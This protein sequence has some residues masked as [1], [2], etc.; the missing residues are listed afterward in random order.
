MPGTAAPGRPQPAAR[1][2]DDAAAR[3]GERRHA[4]PRR[5]RFLRVQQHADR[6]VGRSGAHHLHRRH[7]GRRAARP[8]RLPPGPLAAG[9]HRPGRARLRSRR[10]ARRA[11]RTRERQGASGT[12]ADVP[13]GHRRRP[14]RARRRDQARARRAAPVPAVG[15]GQQRAHERT[16]RPRTRQPLLRI[17]APPPARLRLHRGGHQADPQP[18][19]GHRQGAARLDGQRYAD[20][21][22]LRPQPHAVRLLHAE[23]RAGHQ[24]AARLGARTDRHLSWNRRSAPSRTCWRTPNC[25]PRRS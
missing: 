1:H 11:H 24:P 10:A 3:L 2:P 4:R 18:H 7:A 16:A 22:A 6:T 12:G 17:G 21:R 15:G 25:T 19:G 20:G 8:Q 23:V 5:A 9:R 13:C 14:H